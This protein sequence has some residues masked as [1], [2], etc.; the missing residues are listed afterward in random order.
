MFRFMRLSSGHRYKNY[1]E[2]FND[3]YIFISKIIL[4]FCSEDM[5]IQ[6]NFCND[7]PKIRKNCG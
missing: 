4:N 6:K 2:F 1:F 3:F 7:A 5:K